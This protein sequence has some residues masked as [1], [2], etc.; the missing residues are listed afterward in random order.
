MRERAKH[1]SQ[2][3]TIRRAPAEGPEPDATPRIEDRRPRSDAPLVL[4]R[5]RLRRRLGSG[6][7]ATVWLARDERLDRDVAVKILPRERIVGGRFEREARAA[8]RLAHPA[9]VTLYEAAVDDEGAYL[10]SELV[11]G[12]TLAELL[13]AGRLSDRDVVRIGI[14]LCDAL[15]HAHAHGVI[16]R[17]VKPSNVLVPERASTSTQL[18]RLTDFGVARILDSHPAHHPPESLTMTGD[19][20]GTA[21]YMAPEQAQGLP[22]G[23]TADLFS[24]ALVLYE[25]LSGVNPVRDLSSHPSTPTH[26]GARSARRAGAY[27]PPLR[28]QR[29]D[30]PRELGRAIDLAL[31]PRAGER[32]TLE[33]LRTALV[34]AGGR[35]ADEPGVVAAPWPQ[36]TLTQRTP[37]PAEVDEPGVQAAIASHDDRHEGRKRRAATPTPWPRRALAAAASAALTVWLARRVPGVSPLPAPLIGCLAAALV[38]ALPRVGWLILTAALAG[39]LAA[40]SR[41]GAALLLLTAALVP[42]LL[43]PRDGPTWPIAAAAPALNAVGLATAWPALAGFAGTARRRVALAATGWLWIVLSRP[44]QGQGLTTV[45]TLHDATAHVLRPLLTLGTPATC[46]VWALAAIILPLTRIRRSPELEYIRTAAWATA[47]ALGT[48]ATASLGGATS[49][50]SLGA[51]LLGAYLGGIVAIVTRRVM[52]LARGHQNTERLRPDRV[53]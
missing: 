13:D 40:H 16:H 19:V 1:P 47:L 6:G 50:P 31:R 25:A 5:Y 29:R 8:A 35:V 52:A 34:F 27:L 7:F 46:A 37:I 18:A 15:A 3:P 26:P 12:A 17:D 4:D 24:L 32:G 9:I 33:E 45:A 51:A 23:A 36:R 28:R 22:A 11:H 10:V 20:I 2:A 44:D 48:I 49:S 30:L 42:V 39:S 43:S 38:A 53:A 21:A 41:P 14:A